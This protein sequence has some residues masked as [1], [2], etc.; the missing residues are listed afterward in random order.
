MNIVRALTLTQQIG[1]VSAALRDIDLRFHFL[2]E[3]GISTGLRISDLLN[4]QPKDFSCPCFT[5]T[6]KK[7]GNVRLIELP[8]D[9]FCLLRG[10]IALK[11]LKPA[12][13]LFHRTQ[14]GVWIK[15]KPMSRQWA[16]K[17]ISSTASKLG[18]NLIGTHSMR[19]IYSCGKFRA[20]GSL[21][22]VQEELGHKKLE[23]TLLYL[24][25]LIEQS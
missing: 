8:L 12:D 23:T 13:F 2:W 6:E 14:K 5:V 25:D 10:Y 21:R 18:L 19:K 1:A 15:D 7:T 22:A 11:R 24:R 17:I 20:T 3:M 9:T 4:L 16:W